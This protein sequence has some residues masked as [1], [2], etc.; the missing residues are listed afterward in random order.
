MTAPRESVHEVAERHGDAIYFGRIG[1]SDE[2]KVQSCWPLRRSKNQSLSA[3]YEYQRR[4][5]TMRQPGDEIVKSLVKNE[6]FLTLGGK[7]FIKGILKNQKKTTN[8][9]D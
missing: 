5:K 2:D 1:F 8:V 6:K 9:I 7:N 3:A 4:V